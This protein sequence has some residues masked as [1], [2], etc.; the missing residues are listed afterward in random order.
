MDEINN[1]VIQLYAFLTKLTLNRM[2]E[3]VSN[4][5]KKHIPQKH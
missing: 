2:I 5:K 3:E 4:L 1:N